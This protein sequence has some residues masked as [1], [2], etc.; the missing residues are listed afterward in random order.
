MAFHTIEPGERTLHGA[1][2]RELAP[3][4][5]I[6]SGDTVRFRTLD[7]DWNLAPR[8]STHYPEKPEQWWPRPPGLRHIASRRAAGL[9]HGAA[10]GLQR[11]QALG[12]RQIEEMP[13]GLV[14][15]L[16]DPDIRI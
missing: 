15:D 8:R 9:R 5:T 6:D 4:L 10:S 16:D 14:L 12:L 2:S 7:A 13:A 11:R 1:F 3:A